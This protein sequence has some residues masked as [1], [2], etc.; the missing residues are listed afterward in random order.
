MTM[1]NWVQKPPGS[2]LRK[3][4][5]RSSPPKARKAEVSIAAPSRMMKTSDVVFAVSSIT[6]CSVFSIRMTRTP[7]QINAMTSMT[8]PT[9]PSPIP[10]L[11]AAVSTAFTFISKLPSAKPMTASAASARSAGA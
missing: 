11:S 8:A 6:P 1:T 9:A 7:L 2:E 3:S 4:R 10:K 5:T